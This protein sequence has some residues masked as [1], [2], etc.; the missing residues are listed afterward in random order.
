MDGALGIHAVNLVEEGYG[1][2]GELVIILVRYIRE[3]HVQDLLL[4]HHPVAPLNA[5][6]ISIFIVELSYI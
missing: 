1:K 6:V 2:E 3:K 5:Q 4:N